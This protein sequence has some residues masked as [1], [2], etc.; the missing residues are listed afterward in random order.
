MAEFGTLF[1]FYTETFYEENNLPSD[2]ELYLNQKIAH[3]LRGR[4]IQQ[5][6]EDFIK[7]EDN[8]LVKIA[9]ASSGQQET[10]PLITILKGVANTTLDL[11][12]QDMIIYI[13]EPEA[14]L[15]P[16]TQKQIVE[17]ISAIY[18]L[19]PDKIQIF[20]TTHSP[21]ILTAFNNLVTAGQLIDSG[22]EEE[23]VH[24][25]VSKYEVLS[26]ENLS[27]YSMEAGGAKDITDLE[28]GLIDAEQIDDVSDL[29][30]TQFDQ[31]LA[32]NIDNI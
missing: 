3:I 27:A 20:V 4:Y 18:N 17:L 23:A 31:L 5:N 25:I 12:E 11:P 16:T 7:H 28:Y 10:F 8:R 24:Q 6:D 1:Q 14:H 21:Y 9:N 26:P 13:E 15:F 32:L 30:N 29:I 22:I 19:N 2:L